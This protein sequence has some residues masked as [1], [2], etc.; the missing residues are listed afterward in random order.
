[1]L[2][3]LILLANTS[4]LHIVASLLTRVP[5]LNCGA[6]AQNGAAE[7]KHRHILETARALLLS[8]ELPPHFWAEVVSTAVFLINRQ[9]SPFLQGCTP[10]ERL[11]GHPPNYSHLRCFGCACFVL[12]P[13]R[14]RTKLIAQSVECIFLGYG[15]EHKGYRCYDPVARRMR[16]SRDVTF[17]E[18]PFLS[19]FLLQL[20]FHYCGVYLLLDSSRRVFSAAVHSTITTS[21]SFYNSSTST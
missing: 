19:S 21:C 20:L 13:P 7:R 16:I 9:P 6:H 8:S 14:E 15:T 17:D 5:F 1:V 18:S 4:L 10:Y 12:L 3:V 2:F 11:F